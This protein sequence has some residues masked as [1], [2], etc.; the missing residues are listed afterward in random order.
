[1]NRQSGSLAPIPV[2][3]RNTNSAQQQPLP[4]FPTPPNSKRKSK[5]GRRSWLFPNK[6]RSSPIWRPSTGHSP[7]TPQW[8][9]PRQPIT[10]LPQAQS[11]AQA[12]QKQQVQQSQQPSEKPVKISHD[13]EPNPAFTRTYTRPR[14]APQPP[15][16]TASQSRRSSTSSNTPTLTDDAPVSPRTRRPSTTTTANALAPHPLS[17]RFPPPNPPRPSPSSQQQHQQHQRNASFQTRYM[18]MAMSTERIPRVHNI[19]SNIFAWMILLAFILAPANFC[20][21]V[22]GGGRADDD[23]D[24]GA[25]PSAYKPIPSIALLAV[26]CAIFGLG[27]LGM[28][29]LAL[30]WRRNYIWLMNRI[31]LPLMLNSLAGLIGSLVIVDIQNHMWFSVAAY[32]SLGIEGATL[33]L[34]GG[35]F[36]YTHYL[37]LGKLKREHVRETST[38]NV[39]DLVK[40]GKRPP[41]AP[42]SVV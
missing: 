10:Q 30:C 2:T 40:A 6:P 11:Q 1:M 26:S 4:L 34:S 3:P 32:V 27:S 31:Y 24:D 9:L 16:P 15:P 23:D 13:E 20:P 5:E 18:N 36:F 28:L 39:V 21:Q 22:G 12:Q 17:P 42:G 38:K 33:L 14:E 37:L 29:W 8:P 41:F 25:Q 35:L 19:L 7:P